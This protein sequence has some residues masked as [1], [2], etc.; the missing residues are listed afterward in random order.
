MK[1]K[2]FTNPEENVKYWHNGEDIDFLN[3]QDSYYQFII[4]LETSL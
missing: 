2:K 1:L 4:R 3:D